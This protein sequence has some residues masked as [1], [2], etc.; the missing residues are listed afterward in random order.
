[1]LSGAD[2]QRD[3]ITEGEPLYSCYASPY[4][5]DIVLDRANP[6]CD[7]V[8]RDEFNTGK[9]NACVRSGLH[10]RHFFF[11]KRQSSQ[12]ERCRSRFSTIACRRFLVVREKNDIDMGTCVEGPKRD[13]PKIINLEG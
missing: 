5:C 6:W 12:F 4:S 7:G 11:K 9:E 2:C 13:C 8:G 10:L 3:R 1:M